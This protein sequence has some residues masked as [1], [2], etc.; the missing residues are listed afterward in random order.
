[1]DRPSDMN[2]N[3]WFKAARC[4][5]LNQLANEAFHLASRHPPTHSAPMLMTHPALLHIPF[6]IRAR[7]LIQ[8]VMADH[9]TAMAAMAESTTQMGTSEGTLVEREVDDSDFV[10]SSR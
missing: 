10:R 5:D 6:S 4:I 9:D 7:Q 1:M 8:H 3:G 2:F